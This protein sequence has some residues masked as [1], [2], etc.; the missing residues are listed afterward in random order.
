MT[1]VLS[2][3][4][5]GVSV[6]ALLQSCLGRF[7]LEVDRPR[8]EFS[9]SPGTVSREGIVFEEQEQDQPDQEGITFVI[10]RAMISIAR[11]AL[12][13]AAVPVRILM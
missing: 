7:E 2:L 10:C 11:K 5:Y 13:T 3:G 12:G 8:R 6:I 9:D 4:F 1:G